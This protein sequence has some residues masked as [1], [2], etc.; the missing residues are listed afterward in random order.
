MDSINKIV[1]SI[2]VNIKNI[3]ASETNA[4]NKETDLIINGRSFL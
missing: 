4:L 3:L 1:S 2:R